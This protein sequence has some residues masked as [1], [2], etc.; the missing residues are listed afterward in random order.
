M[1]VHVDACFKLMCMIMLDALFDH[2]L[3]SD[4]YDEHVGI[5]KTEVLVLF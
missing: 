5:V 1:H 4:V 3:F 2:H